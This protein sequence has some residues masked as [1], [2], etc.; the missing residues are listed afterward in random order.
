MSM[1]FKRADIV[2]YEDGIAV[3]ATTSALR[4][5]SCG[6]NW[7][8]PPS[9]EH[10][11]FWNHPECDFY[12]DT[13]KLKLITKNHKNQLGLGFVDSKGFTTLP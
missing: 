13:R 6:L 5:L 1:K 7:M 11:W 4:P 9:E 10:R 8:I 2:A 12:T 3:V